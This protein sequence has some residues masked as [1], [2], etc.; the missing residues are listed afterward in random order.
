MFGSR[1]ETVDQ[2]R[3]VGAAKSYAASATTG[4]VLV[5]LDHDDLLTVDALMQINYV[6][7]KTFPKVGMA[8]PTAP[9]S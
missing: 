2:L 6:F 5:E 7:E 1:S 8:S 3:G 9:R 4:P